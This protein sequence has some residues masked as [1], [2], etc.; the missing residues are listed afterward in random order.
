MIPQRLRGYLYWF[1]QLSLSQGRIK[2]QIKGGESWYLDVDEQHLSHT[3]TLSVI[4]DVASPV[5]DDGDDLLREVYRVTL[6]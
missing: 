5:V 1:Y 6:C 2:K 3:L 4:T